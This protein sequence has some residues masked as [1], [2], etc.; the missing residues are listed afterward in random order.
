M[1]RLFI[2][3][4]SPVEEGT[5]VLVSG[6]ILVIIVHMLYFLGLLDRDELFL[7]QIVC[8][9]VFV[10]IAVSILDT[11]L[12]LRLLKPLNELSKR[13]HDGIVVR[14]NRILLPRPMR[15]LYGY[16]LMVYHPAGKYTLVKVKFVP[17]SDERVV[18]SIKIMP[19]KFI[20][21]LKRGG[22]INMAVPAVKIIDKEYS[23]GKEQ[24]LVILTIPAMR[25]IPIGG[26]IRVKYRED[27]AICNWSLNDIYLNCEVIY[28]PHSMARATRKAKIVLEAPLTDGFRGTTTILI[29]EV[30]EP[31]AVRRFTIELLP[32]NNKPIVIVTNSLLI[33]TLHQSYTRLTKLLKM[34][35]LDVS[36]KVVI[37]GTRTV[38]L[39][40]ILDIP[41]RK[42][43]YSIA[44]IHPSIKYIYG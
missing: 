27:V 26:T 35:R 38:R 34:M 36:R 37:S 19:L 6:V 39:K 12:E 42:D 31:Y 32:D 25:F 44:K 3:G 7:F 18:N 1:K 41:N 8:L 11:L 29:G 14:D 4:V 16:I 40:L 15:I 33:K 23:L 28:E 2:E 17:T 24:Y 30:S 43:K 20:T 5:E 21:I 22:S 13:L 9:I 10:L